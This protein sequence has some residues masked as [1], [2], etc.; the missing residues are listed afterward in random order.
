MILLSGK[1]PAESTYSSL[2]AWLNQP[3]HHQRASKTLKLRKR[4][5]TSTSPTLSLAHHFHQAVTEPRDEYEANNDDRKDTISHVPAT[6]VIF[7]HVI[8]VAIWT[9]I[10]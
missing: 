8:A 10:R 5:M 2:T 4:R 7:V 9:W 1:A 3:P 6:K